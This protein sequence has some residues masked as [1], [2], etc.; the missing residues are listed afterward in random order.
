M[1][2][3][4]MRIACGS[5]AGSWRGRSS[6]GG[7]GRASTSWA[8]PRA[9]ARGPLLSAGEDAIGDRGVA[10]LFKGDQLAFA[11]VGE[12]VGGLRRLAVE[13]GGSQDHDHVALGDEVVGFGFDP[14]LGHFGPECNDLL[15]A[16]VGTGQR[17][18]AADRPL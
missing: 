2:S 17:A 15:L 10:D 13:R 18:V 11:V 7:P 5:A 3:A 14:F 16:P 12:D 8:G 4:S 1:A 6:P 9:K